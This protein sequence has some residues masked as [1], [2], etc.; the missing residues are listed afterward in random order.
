M[1][2]ILGRGDSPYV[3][4]FSADASRLFVG[5][6]NM[7]GN[8]VQSLGVNYTQ[9][10][11]PLFEVGSNNRYY[12]VGRTTGSMTMGKVIGPTVISNALIAFLGNPC[13]PGSRRLTLSL[14]NAQCSGAG[15]GTVFALIADA[16]VATGISYGTQ[17]NDLLVNEQ[18]QVMFG[19][20][21]RT[22]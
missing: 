9:P 13:A 17:A 5:A 8:L 16:C 12:V 10:V 18:L 7:A 6:L 15:A 14:G 4:A 2:D 21:Q 20:L 11:S 1:A 19:Q 22:P 3:G